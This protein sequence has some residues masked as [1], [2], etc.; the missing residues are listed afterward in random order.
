MSI[1]GSG[2][3]PSAVVYHALRNFFLLAQNRQ[4]S[5]D[6]RGSHKNTFLLMVMKKWWLV[7]TSPYYLGLIS[8]VPRLRT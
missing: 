5:K 7:I 1:Y 2:H 3:G 4:V 6:L 8:R